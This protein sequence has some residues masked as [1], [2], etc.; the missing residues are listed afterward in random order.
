MDDVG[1]GNGLPVKGD[2]DGSL[3][4]WGEGNTNNTNVSLSSIW[5]DMLT[6]TSS[7]DVAVQITLTLSCN[8]TRSLPEEKKLVWVMMDEM[9]DW[10][11]HCG[12]Q[13]IISAQEKCSQRDYKEQGEH[14]LQEFENLLVQVKQMPNY[15]VLIEWGSLGSFVTLSSG[16]QNFHISRGS[17]TLLW[18]SRLT[19]ASFSSLAETWKRFLYI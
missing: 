17:I 11:I 5:Y 14:V 7:H 8:I 19:T 2:I 10:L 15:S 12:V 9:H 16:I 6:T 18:H 1:R 13:L 4:C 3:E